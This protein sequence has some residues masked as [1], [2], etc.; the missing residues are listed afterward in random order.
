MRSEQAGRASPGRVGLLAIAVL[1]GCPAADGNPGYDPP[2]NQF[3]FPSGLLIDPRVS[4]EPGNACADTSECAAGER[5]TSGGVCRAAPRWLFV[6]NA[7][8]DRSAN[9]GTLLALDLDAFHSAAFD[10]PGAID[11]ATRDLVPRTVWADNSPVCGTS[12]ADGTWCRR[13]ANLPQVVECLEEPFVCSE[14]TIHFGNFPGPTVAWDQ[15]PGDDEAMLLIPVRGDPSITY[16][17]LSGGLDGGDVRFECGQASD[18]DGGRYCSDDYRLRFLRNDPDASRLAREPFRIL[19][20]TEPG[21]PIAYV[22][23]QGDRDITL[24]ALD[25]MTHGDDRPTMVHQANLLSWDYYDS[26]QGGF[27]LAQRP[28]DVDSGNAPNS[29]LD[30]TRPLIYAAMRYTPRMVT[31]TAINYDLPVCSDPDASSEVEADLLVGYCEAQAQG[32]RDIPSVGELPPPFNPNNPIPILGDVGFSRS[33]NELYIVQSNP[34]ALLRLDTSIGVDGETLDVP[35]GQV[36]VCGSPTSFAIY[37]DGGS[38]FGIVTCYR[39]GEVFIVD[40]ASLTVVGVSRAGIG[41]DAIAVDLAREVIYVAN[42]LDET[43]S[44]ID[45]SPAKSTRFTQI[46]RIGIQDPYEQ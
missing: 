33:G 24:F 30:C 34:G 13:A 27:G 6:T 7:N 36:E 3:A 38:Q 20:S 19:V 12:S 16:A 42:T 25:G 10:D 5:C 22:S 2:S 4:M 35:A 46:A 11:P 45:M 21:R 44:V 31:L 15:T 37:D 40:L 9:A 43:I 26:F 17:K 41:P 32:V 23:H 8:S 18:E 39:S 29:T 28:C 14:A 1:T